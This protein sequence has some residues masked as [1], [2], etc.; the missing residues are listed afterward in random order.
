MHLGVD[1]REHL[2]RARGAGEHA[3]GA[4]DDVDRGAGLGGDERSGEVAERAEVL[5]QRAGDERRAR[6]A[7]G[8]SNS[9]IGRWLIARAP[10][11][12]RE[13]H[14]LGARAAGEHEAA[15]E[16]ARR[17]REVGAGV[18]AARLA[19]VVA[20]ARTSAVLTVEE[21]GALDVGGRSSPASTSAARVEARRVCGRTPASRVMTR[22][23]SSRIDGPA[24][25]AH[26]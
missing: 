7:T 6:R 11:R 23:S 20:A 13:R 3:V 19:P 22:C 1:L 21:V 18:R 10:T 15:E 25:G 9:L 5:G 14:E 4:R 24:V 16:R 26:R 17:L 8:A 12:W 2:G